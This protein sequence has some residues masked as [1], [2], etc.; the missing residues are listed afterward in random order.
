MLLGDEFQSIREGT[1]SFAD[2]EELARREGKPLVRLSLMTSYRS[3]PEI[4]DLFASLLPEER[5][6]LISSVRP[7]GETVTVRACGTDEEYCDALKKLTGQ[8][9]QE[10]GLTGIICRT[11]ARLKDLTAMLG[12]A[13]PPVVG[14]QDTLPKKGA[15]LMELALA[16]GLEFDRVILPDVDPDT[17]PEDQLS[18]HCLY[19]A[20]S[21]ATGCLAI[22]A[23]G[24]V[25]GLLPELS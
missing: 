5:K 11:S 22:L 7:P 18:R 16:K 19:T 10:E 9:E 24:E 25:S 15:F 21:R 4:T 1:A 17:Y 6:L 3:S 8:Y 12:R 14:S 20:V 13:A 23:R 2:I